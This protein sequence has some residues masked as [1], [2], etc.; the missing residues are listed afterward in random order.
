MQKKLFL[1]S[2]TGQGGAGGLLQCIGGGWEAAGAAQRRRERWRR[3]GTQ[4]RAWDVPPG[5]LLAGTKPE[6][7]SGTHQITIGWKPL[8]K[9]GKTSGWTV[10]SRK[11]PALQAWDPWAFLATQLDNRWADSLAATSDLARI[12][13]PYTTAL[14]LRAIAPAT[15]DLRPRPSRRLHNRLAH[16]RAATG[17][18]ILN[19]VLRIYNRFLAAGRVAAPPQTPSSP[20]ET[21]GVTPL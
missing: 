20:R 13:A 9:C 11:R 3:R 10:E 21:L 1:I 7:R 19:D 12:L 5:C 16:R 4:K 2:M 8:R 18:L 17:D 15:R 6:G 14:S